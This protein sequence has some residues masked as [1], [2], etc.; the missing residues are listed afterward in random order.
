MGLLKALD[1]PAFLGDLNAAQKKKWSKYISDRLDGE[2]GAAS[3]HHFYNPLVTDTAADMKT[4][5]ISWTAFPRLVQI[6]TATD[7]QR[8][9]KADASRD[10]QDEYCE[11]S[12]ERDKKSKIT[13]VT[14]TCESPEY[15]QRLAEENPA[16]VLELY[17]KYISKSVKKSDLFSGGAYVPRNKWNNSTTMGA[18][19]LVQDNNTLFA[20]LNIAVRSTIIRKIRGTILTGER[21]LIDC[22]RY[23]APQRHSDPHI[24]GEINAL[25]R[26]QAD[27]TIA[28]PVGLYI[29]DLDTVGWAAPD[30]SDPKKYWKIV[31]GDA[32]HA[33][34]AVY[35]VPSTKKFKVGDITINGQP[36][37]YGGQITDFITIKVMGQ[38]C[39][40]GK[41]TAAPVT[42]CVPG[43]SFAP[44]A[45]TAGAAPASTGLTRA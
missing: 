45:V 5:E 28:N 23:G 14:F 15:W 8:W 42:S 26:Q 44:G 13:K 20:E 25:A 41:S 1:P 12:V 4:A 37:E 39:R 38:A 9:Q 29:R 35:E 34:R 24:G 22:G 19:H 11:W 18:M 27:V 6:S 36:I 17:Q 31:R 32:K 3:G 2:L 10:E 21:E 16:K 40:F 33:V 30:G 7:E 43:A